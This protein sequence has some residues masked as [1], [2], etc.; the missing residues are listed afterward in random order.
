MFYRT[1]SERIPLKE[2]VQAIAMYV[3]S[4]HPLAK[5]K[6]LE[7]L[8]GIAATLRHATKDIAR[9]SLPEPIKTLLS[10]LEAREQSNGSQPPESSS[11]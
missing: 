1:R 10:R 6:D 11:R 5:L 9:E 7:F 2:R 3:P 8:D 4:D